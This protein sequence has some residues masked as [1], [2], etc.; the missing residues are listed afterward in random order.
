MQSWQIGW[1][2]DRKRTLTPPD[3]DPT[4]GE[5]VTM[6][7]IADYPVASTQTNPVVTKIVTG[8]GRDLFVGF[9]R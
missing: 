7:G 1:Y 8:N 6:V 4:W 2:N 5:L 9:N 3:D